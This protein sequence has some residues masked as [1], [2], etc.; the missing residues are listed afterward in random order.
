MGTQGEGHKITL[1]Q[2]SSYFI[3]GK[4]GESFFRQF[5]VAM[6]LKKEELKKQG[7]VDTKVSKVTKDDV[8]NAFG[9]TKDHMLEAAKILGNEG[10]TKNSGK[11]SA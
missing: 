1:L 5:D 6:Q 10:N 2:E 4:F 7:K 9:V 3:P 11:S 8:I